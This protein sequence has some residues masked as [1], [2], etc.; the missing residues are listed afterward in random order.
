MRR[1]AARLLIAV[2]ALA[3]GGTAAGCSAAPGPAYAQGAAR[4]AASAAFPA[5]SATVPESAHA[6][7]TPAPGTLLVAG[8]PR[9]VKAREGI[10]VDEAT[11]QV[12]WARGV[13]RIHPIAS[14]TK[15]MTA[16]VI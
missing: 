14:I 16:L 1:L 5:P 4:P 7:T 6:K 8:T 13:N 12:L 9:G 3:V 10:L 11:G 15:V 2:T